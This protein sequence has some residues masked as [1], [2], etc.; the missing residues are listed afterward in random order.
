MK[1]EKCIQLYLLQLMVYSS[2]NYNTLFKAA[3]KLYIQI[4]VKDHLKH[5]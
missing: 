2:Y 1:G 4:K 3:Y 5:I